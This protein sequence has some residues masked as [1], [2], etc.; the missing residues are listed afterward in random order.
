MRAMHLTQPVARTK[1]LQMPFLRTR[2]V[3]LLSLVA[4]AGDRAKKERATNGFPV[5]RK[6]VPS[7]FS[8]PEKKEENRPIKCSTLLTRD[9][10]DLCSFISHYSRCRHVFLKTLKIYISSWLD[11]RA[12]NFREFMVAFTFREAGLLKSKWRSEGNRKFCLVATRATRWLAQFLVFSRRFLW[13]LLQFM[14]W[15]IFKY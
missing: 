8:S 7:F 4:R 15:E 13:L 2:L 3:S 1:N 9:S 6:T 14:N 12:R 10:S 11:A 5:H